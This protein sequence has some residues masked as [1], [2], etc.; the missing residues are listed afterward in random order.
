M[1]AGQANRKKVD[2]T[3]R[4]RMDRRQDQKDEK[5]SLVLKA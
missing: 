3:A 5:E 4:K 1:I 2:Q